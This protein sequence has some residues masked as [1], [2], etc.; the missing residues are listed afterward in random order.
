MNRI[1][2]AL[3]LSVAGLI[4]SGCVTHETRPQTRV[5][6][7][8]AAAEIPADQLLDVGVALRAIGR[9]E[10]ELG[11]RQTTVELRELLEAAGI[12][13]IQ[14]HDLAGREHTPVVGLR[15]VAE[16]RQALPGISVNAGR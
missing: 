12:V 16:R 4:V 3:A 9:M 11:A 8:Q 10:H 14:A 1:I 2:A 13:A 5:K 6:A 7:I 15:V